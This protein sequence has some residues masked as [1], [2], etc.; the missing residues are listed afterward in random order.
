MTNTDYLPIGNTEDLV[1]FIDNGYGCKWENGNSLSG[2]CPE[3]DE[4]LKD[5]YG[6]IIYQEQVMQIVQAI[7]KMSLGEADMVR[8]AIG[9]KDPELMKELIA[10]MR[11]HDRIGGI[12]EEQVD[13]ILNTIEVGSGYLFNKSHSAAY[14]YTA[15][16]TAYL[17]T[18]F[19]LQFYTALLNANID[20]EKTVEYLKEVRRNG[21]GIL[22]PDIIQSDKEWKIEGYDLRVGLQTIRGVGKVQFT[23]PKTNTLEGFKEFLG[24]NR[25]LN[26]QV[27]ENLVKAGCFNISPAWGIDYIEWFKSTKNREEEIKE[28]MYYYS[29]TKPNVTRCQQW[30]DKLKELP[31]EP[32]YYET[33]VLDKQKM[34]DEVLGMSNVNIFPMYDLGL[35]EKNRN[36]AICQV[37][38]VRCFVSKK[39][40]PTIM[41]DG[42][43]EM[44]SIKFILT[45]DE[46]VMEKAKEDIK[47][48]DV[49]LVRVYPFTNKFKR[50]Q[51][52]NEY[53]HAKEKAVSA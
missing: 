47:K 15:Y 16:Q 14:A 11:N 31:P 48:G 38:S 32:A 1:T 19:P 13:H 22:F 33:P 7:F 39:H 27:C 20:Q 4:I 9:R 46:N 23:K 25:R 50:V 10:K 18:H 35:A 34:Q 45:V 12:S 42:K 52:G 53:I 36:N 30:S 24:Q 51:F 26:K 49:L 2:I 21:F 17:K 28:R 44:G 8:R 29:Q 40:N 6:C 3:I 43:D 5:T 41:I 37:E